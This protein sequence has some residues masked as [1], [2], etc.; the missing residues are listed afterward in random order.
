MKQAIKV[1]NEQQWKYLIS[2]APKGSALSKYPHKYNTSLQKYLTG[3]AINVN[4]TAH[5]GIDWYKKEGYEI[6]SFDQFIKYVN[7]KVDDKFPKEG[8]CYTSIGLNIFEDYFKRNNYNGPGQISIK[9]AVGIAWNKNSYWFLKTSTSSKK[10]FYYCDLYKFIRFKSKISD[11][12]SSN[13]VEKQ[14]F[15]IKKKSIKDLKSNEAIHCK[16][17]EEAEAICKLMHEAGFKWRSGDSFLNVT[18]WKFLENIY[19][20]PKLGIYRITKHDD[21][22]I[23]Y[24]ANYFLT[25][26]IKNSPAILKSYI[27]KYI[28]FYYG[29]IFYNKGYVVEEDDFIFILNNCQSNN[30]DHTIYRDKYKYSLTFLSSEMMDSYIKDIKILDDESCSESNTESEKNNLSYI[31]Y[32]PDISIPKIDKNITVD[33]HIS[34]INIPKKAISI[35]VFRNIITQPIKLNI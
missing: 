2:L 32:I 20:L 16:T 19:Y 6:I 10:S 27:G 4:L 29:D 34:E 17:K 1:D 9:E 35:K 7:N 25:E 11:L 23:I 21:E 12:P 3:L 33:I 30:D 13:P 5:C 14:V 22:T 24:E 18:K 31:K 15:P 28:S 8:C 26:E